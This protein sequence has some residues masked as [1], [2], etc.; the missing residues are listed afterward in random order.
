MNQDQLVI[1]KTLTRASLHDGFFFFSQVNDI[2]FHII[3]GSKSVTLGEVR[4][5]V[6]TCL[7]I[8]PNDQSYFSLKTLLK[9]EQRFLFLKKFQPIGH[10]RVPPGLCF[11]TRVGAQPLMWKSFFILMQIK[12][13]FTRKVVH[14]ASF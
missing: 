10:F 3:M 14:L 2:T 8:L 4:K 9:Y 7:L 6:K 11:K 1:R 12:L 5:A 13:I